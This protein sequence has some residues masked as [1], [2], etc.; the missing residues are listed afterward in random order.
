M[1]TATDGEVNGGVDRQRIALSAGLPCGPEALA[2]RSA[3]G[4][5]WVW[6]FAPGEPCFDLELDLGDASLP[7]PSKDLR[8]QHWCV[9]LEAWLGGFGIGECDL[10]GGGLGL[11]WLV[12]WSVGLVGT[13][14]SQ[15]PAVELD[16][17]E[18][19]AER[20]AHRCRYGHGDH[21]CGLRLGRGEAVSA[22]RTV[23]AGAFRGPE[24]ESPALAWMGQ[25]S[26]VGDGQALVGGTAQGDGLVVVVPSMLDALAQDVGPVDGVENRS[27]RG[28]WVGVGV[29]D[30]VGV[31]WLWG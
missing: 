31:E 24:L 30:W 28:V 1:G 9:W 26:G 11:R 10:E 21:L 23:G 13:M 6:W 20:F 19:G 5:G 22:H 3:S 25:P 12:G 8:P 4:D 15:A 17:L 18:D 16:L 2:V 14:A 29:F 7:A 27:H